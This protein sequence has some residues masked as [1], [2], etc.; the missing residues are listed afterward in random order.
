MMDFPPP[1]PLPPPNSPWEQYITDNGEVYYAHKLTG[2]TSWTLPK[3][4][5]DSI[6]C[7]PS[8]PILSSMEP[9]VS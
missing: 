2:E 9:G 3:E 6:G 4:R 1:N 7:P 5:S 8:L